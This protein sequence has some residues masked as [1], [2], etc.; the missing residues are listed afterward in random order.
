MAPHSHLTKQNGEEFV[1]KIKVM[2][3][4]AKTLPILGLIAV[5]AVSALSQTTLTAIDGRRIDLAGQDGKVV[6]VAVGTSWLPLSTKQA[7][8]ANILAK[9]YSGKNVAMYFLMTDSTDP[10]SKNH[11]SN[12]TLAKFATDNK[13]T[14]PILRDP[15]GAA[16][17]KKFGI[18]QVPSFLILGKDGEKVQI[19]GGINPKMDITVPISKTVDGLL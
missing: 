7:E 8:F 14:M 9:K 3:I 19:F 12:D 10:K 13:L 11:A 5:F 4:F 17:F 15:D 6:I 1:R 18:D 2:K 16:T